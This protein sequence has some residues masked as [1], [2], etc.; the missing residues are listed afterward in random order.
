[1]IKK[2][3]FKNIY[4]QPIEKFTD[5]IM[6]N[7]NQVVE[8]FFKKEFEETK[9]NY[10]L[11]DAC[12][13]NIREAK[14][15]LKDTYKEFK[16]GWRRFWNGLIFFLFFILIGFVFW[17]IYKKNKETIKDYE[18]LER[19]KTKLIRDNIN[20][21]CQQIFSSF[22][23]ITLKDIYSYAFECYGIKAVNYF[24]RKQVIDEIADD[25]IIDIYSGVTGIVKN[26]PFYDVIARKLYYS[27]ITTSN[28]MSFPYTVTV[29]DRDGFHTETRWESLTAY[30]TE[31]TPF[32]D[33]R[34]L[35]IYKTNYLK[36]LSVTNNNNSYDKNILLENK[37]FVNRVK[38]NDLT[39]NPQKLS[40]FFT[41]KTQE[42]FVNWYNHENN[43]VFN[44]IKID[45]RFAVKNLD[46]NI[47]SLRMVNKTIDSLGLV[48]IS[49][50]STLD[51]VK[52]EIKKI[53]YKYF[54]KF[55]KMLQLPLL[56]PGIS[57]EWY[58]KNGNY[59]IASDSV[60][61]IEEIDK[62][63]KIRPIDSINKFLDPKFY[64]FKKDTPAKPIWFSE[65]KEVTLI[66]NCYV[67]L[68]VM[69]SFSGEK[70]IE[71]VAVTGFHVGTKIIPVQYERF[72][73]IQEEKLLITLN[74]RT[75]TDT[76]FLFGPNIK[77]LIPDNFYSNPDL[78]KYVKEYGIW[79]NNPGDFEKSVNNSIIIQMAKEFRE[80]NKQYD[81]LATLRIDEYGLYI[82]VD[83]S[84][85][86]NGEIIGQLTKM[87]N[88]FSKLNYWNK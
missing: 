61:E 46:Y 81:L 10:A 4:D 33:E 15:L 59:L 84:H 58:R 44:F 43:R 68:M 71:N 76:L 24:N 54:D 36:E 8:D 53:V 23:T 67:G 20:T 55:T 31:S 74:K 48:K 35:L 2:I 87:L 56:V 40:E 5:Y 17:P 18:E 22:S 49:E 80:I 42:D 32:V 70:L 16:I 11:M 69:K 1:M 47:D 57:R 3:D 64:T 79:T 7:L 45:N 50:N 26:S 77:G 83:N 66:N 72:T 28:T 85:N 14:Q 21:K 30:H 52:Y 82:A 19:Q 39:N 13:Q 78:L 37:D 73:P 62:I 65:G 38:I 9:P 6:N 51:G 60:L 63:E 29:H 41:I 12:D 75:I 86:L 88:K 34:N 27:D 25:Q